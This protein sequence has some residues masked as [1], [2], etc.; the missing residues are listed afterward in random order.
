MQAKANKSTKLQGNS[1]ENSRKLNAK[2]ENTGEGNAKQEQQELQ[3]KTEN[4]STKISYYDVA[5]LTVW[6]L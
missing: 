6:W 2:D 4:A 3:N 5:K 1:G